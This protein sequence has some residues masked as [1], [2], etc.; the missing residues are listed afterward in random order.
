MSS[1]ARRAL[2]AQGFYPERRD[3]EEAPLDRVVINALGH[4]ARLR[5][6]RPFRLRAIVEATARGGEGLEGLSDEELGWQ[7]RSLRPSLRAKGFDMETVGRV[8]ALVREFSSRR[9]GLRHFDVQLMGGWALLNGMVAEMRTGEG[10][11]LV[12][13]LPAS[14]AALAGIPVHVVTVNDYLSHRDAEWMRP[15]YEAMGLSVGCITHGMTPE[16]RREAYGCDVTY[17][18]NKELAFD[19]LRDHLALGRRPGPIQMRV[20]RFAGEQKRTD[21]LS[22]RGLFY[23]IVDE[24]DSVLVDEARTP[25]II[26]GRGDSSF[27]TEFYRQALALSEELESGR[28]YFIDFQERRVDLTDEG[29]DRLEELGIEA[30]GFWTGEMRREEFVRKALSA[31]HL[32]QRDKNYVVVDGRV[33]I[34]DEY[35]GRIMPG[36]TWEGGL[37]QLIEAKECC[38]VTTQTEV[39]ARISYQRFFRR[40]LAL[41]GMTG[42]AREASSELWAVY[43][44]EV[45]SI[46]TNRPMHLTGHPSSVYRT[47]DEKWAAIVERIRD[48]NRRG[49]PVLVG[50]RTVSASRHLAELLAGAEISCRVLNALQ[51]AEE[52]EIIAEAGQEG[53]VTVATNMAGRGTDIK[54]GEGVAEMGGLHVI[55]TERHDAGRIDRQLFGRCGRQGDPGSF[56]AFVSLEDDLLRLKPRILGVVG[57]GHIRPGSAPSRWLGRWL[58]HK[59]QKMA[60]RAHH[61]MRRDLM[62]HD[63]SLQN[64]LAF[65]GSGE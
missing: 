20:E 22:L 51:D 26:S 47:L 39:L 11:T 1:S 52:A 19:Y 50:T 43:R 14:T 64:A 12:A 60:E 48:L 34:V 21:Q 18:T 37:H 5:R 16:A 17:C 56:E 53:Q 62:K 42:T 4:L 36:R 49:R 58:V 29:R 27:E 24:A 57:P 2:R 46:P 63:E 10:K 38:D 41:A 8:F 54:L 15:V 40:Y 32:F 59:A 13:T 31:R 6:L 9:L 44:L 3:R 25:L 33:Q 23:A 55:A 45:L 7:I 61:R 30:G 65:S 35:T 28:D